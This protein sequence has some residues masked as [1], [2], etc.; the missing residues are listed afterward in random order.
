[1]PSR[2]IYVKSPTASSNHDLDGE[3]FNL[4][5][6]LDA[7]LLHWQ[8]H[9]PK[10]VRFDPDAKTA[11]PNILFRRHCHL[12]HHRF[13]NSRILLFRRLLV[14]L[15][16]RHSQRAAP[17]SRSTLQESLTRSC[18]EICTTAA[19][20]LVEIIE[21]YIGTWL[22]PPAWFTVFCKHSWAFTLHCT[23]VLT[24]RQVLYTAGTVIAVVLL[25]PP[26]RAYSTPEKLQSLRACW[27]Q[28]I[29]CLSEYKK[30][31]APAAAQCLSNL[32]KMH[33][34][35]DNPNHG[36]QSANNV[37]QESPRRENQQPAHAT[38]SSSGWES[39]FGEQPPVGEGNDSDFADFPLPNLWWPSPNYQ[40][41]VD[42]SDQNEYP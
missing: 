9:L 4:L 38:P 10:H 18:I 20:D 6:R 7:K 40:W 2:L 36:S 33:V 24:W 5:L 19:Q 35:I 23:V 8:E 25:T 41:L 3:D 42:L 26:F 11:D 17:P 1:M 15:A 34:G 21:P 22:V 28:C 27:S 37:R 31:G 39:R 30:Q 16:A 29:E 14:Q 32:R 12:L 13:L